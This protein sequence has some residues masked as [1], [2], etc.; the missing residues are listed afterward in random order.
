MLRAG[1]TVYLS[2]I[3]YTARDAAHARICSMLEQNRP[4]PIPLKGQAL[5]YCGPCPAPPGQ[6]IGSCGPTSALRMDKY[7]PTLFDEGVC[8]VIAK[9]PFAFRVH[10]SIERNRA[11]YLCAAGGA[12]ALIARSVLESETVAFEDLGTEGIRRLTVSYMPTIVGIDSYGGSLF[13]IG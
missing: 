2:G 1:D 3:I 9:G 13:H 11:V 5:Y 4:V 7:A 10:E 6:P 12:G 8:A